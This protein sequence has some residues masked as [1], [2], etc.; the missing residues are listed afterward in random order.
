MTGATSREGPPL[1]SRN[2]FHSGP[3][4]SRFETTDP[5]HAHGF[6]RRVY[7]DTALRV[8]GD[9]AAF[10]LTY[11]AR[12]A[13]PVSSATLTQTP[14]VEHRA[15]PLGRLVVGL[16]RGGEVELET[17]G[18]SL[19]A[20]SGD[21]FLAA[22]PD[23]PCTVRAVDLEVQLVEVDQVVVAG[24]AT[25]LP[26]G[27]ALF[28]GC[29][30][31]SAAAAQHTAGL[32]EF[33]GRDVLGNEEAVASPLLV[34]NAARMLGAALLTTFPNTAADPHDGTSSAPVTLRLAL[35][36]IEEHAHEPVSLA[37]IAAATHVTPRTLQLAFRRRLGTTPTEYLRRVRLDR[38]HHDLLAA[39]P[40]ASEG[41]TAIARRWGFLNMG[42]FAA[43]YRQV[44]GRSPREALYSSAARRG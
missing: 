12:G 7:G 30:P 19:R 13:G 16:V 5:R 11:L 22:L 18:E 20:R 8:T 23:R 17:V 34:D 25:G 39:D 6:L 40:A 31:V 10:H 3:W 36:F 9:P 21:V 42:R 38:A 1:S 43:R 33:L 37:Q 4:T 35:A 29:R 2:P 32:L 24:L 14:E 28:T 44:Y 41:V 15:Q 27:P 26:A